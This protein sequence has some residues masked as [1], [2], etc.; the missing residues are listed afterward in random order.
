[1]RIDA[2]NR[3][4]GV[5]GRSATGKAGSGPAF[6]PAG[7]TSAARVNTSAPV[8]PTAG[9]DAILAL[10]AV[11]DFT[12]SR[13]KSVK[14]G[15]GL[16]DLLEAMKA[17]LLVGKVSAERLDTMVLQLGQLRER[18]EPGLDAVIDDIELRVRVELAKLGRFPQF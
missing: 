6:V 8:A 2:T 16:L 12:E 13:R 15:R 17:D 1:M 9:L 18:V 10:Q 14:R 7:E 4:S 3:T 5:A 11:G